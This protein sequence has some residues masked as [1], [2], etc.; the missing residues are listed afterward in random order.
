MDDCEATRRLLGIRNFG[1]FNDND[2][3][4]SDEH[5]TKILG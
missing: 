1:S 3:Q 2:M 5:N 4:L